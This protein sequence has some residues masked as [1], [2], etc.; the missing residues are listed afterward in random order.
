MRLGAG[1]GL[2][3]LSG[4]GGPAGVPIPSAYAKLL[5]HF[6]SDFSDSSINSRVATFTGAPLISSTQSVF[7]E[8]SC[9]FDSGLDRI[10]YPYSGDFNMGDSIPSQISFWIWTGPG[11]QNSQR[12][13][14]A[15]QNE[16]LQQGYSL[17]V[18]NWSTW[19]FYTSGIG[20]E[21]WTYSLP[22][23]TWAP[24]RFNH[25]G[26]NTLRMYANGTLIGAVSR[27]IADVAN[28]FRIGSWWDG[29]NPLVD[30]YLDEFLFE[31]HAELEIT[32]SPTYEVEE[33]PFVIV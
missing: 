19:G 24:L 6:D 14:C 22:V 27:N 7:G 4:A 11:R 17:A 29:G 33:K 10:N 20:T 5:L 15:T 21:Q 16:W 26:A 8:E 12:V 23:N 1:M 9:R 28:G 13:I 32:T 30:A 31:K 25:D 2:T 18:R 3:K